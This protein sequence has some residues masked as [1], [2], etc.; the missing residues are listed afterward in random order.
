MKPNMIK[1]KNTFLTV[2][3]T[4][5]S[6]MVQSQGRIEISSY[7][8]GAEVFINN[9]STQ[10]VTP[11]QLD[12]KPGTYELKLEKNRF[13][14]YKNK[15]T[16]SEGENPIVECTLVPG[17]GVVK[18]ATNPDKAEVYID[19]VFKGSTP[20]FVYD[21]MPGNH[22]IEIKK[23]MYTPFITS[24]VLEPN[25]PAELVYNLNAQFASV[26]IVAFPEADILIDGEKVGTRIYSGRITP[27]THTVEVSQRNYITQ[28]KILEVMKGD[29][30]TLS[31][32]LD[33][34]F[35]KISLSSDPQDAQVYLNNKYIG[36][37]PIYIDSLDMGEY[38]L[39]VKKDDHKPWT[40]TLQINSGATIP[41]NAVLHWGEKVTIISTPV[42]TEGAE[43]YVNGELKG[44]TPLDTRLQAGTYSIDLK[45]RAWDLL[46]TNLVVDGDRYVSYNMVQTPFNLNINSTPGKAEILLDGKVVGKTPFIVNNVKAGDKQVSLSRRGYK[47]LNQTVFIEG[48]APDLNYLLDPLS[49]RTKGEALFLSLLFPGA[50]Q[51]FLNRSGGAIIF[52]FLGYG[53]VAGHLYSNKQAD[54]F[55]TSGNWDEYEKWNNNA[56]YALYGAAGIW[57]LNFLITLGTPGDNAR[58]KKY[59]MTGQVNPLPGGAELGLK[60]DF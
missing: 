33:K 27:G 5:L 24:F 57:G 47:T 23:E 1:V 40:Q 21:L 29:E 9:A 10:Q 19:D 60:I 8:E 46:S 36:L 20:L 2:F 45:K 39:L 17:A 26:G 51:S 53:C 34:L 6:S 49:K 3:C 35:G 18:I 7:P 13:E 48:I 16:V 32:N 55:A 14:T 12:L 22:T 11:L 54:E 31:F 56:M 37:S 44:K 50:G 15:I 58:M 30:F 41:L 25:R 59:K 38:I 42:D 28:S 4:I 43:V 52:T